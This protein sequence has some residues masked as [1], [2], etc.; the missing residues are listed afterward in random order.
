MIEWARSLYRKSGITFVASV[1]GPS[2]RVVTK[3]HGAFAQEVLDSVNVRGR[4]RLSAPNAPAAYPTLC[5]TRSRR[6]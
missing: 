6:V 5:Q 4:T 2:Q 1:H 3:G